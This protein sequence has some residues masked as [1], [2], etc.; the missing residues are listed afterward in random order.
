MVQNPEGDPLFR[1]HESL[2]LA[3]QASISGRIAFGPNAGKLVT[4]IGSGFGYMEEIP[5]AK[6][7]R[8]YSV[9]GFSIHANTSVNALRR[10]KLRKL[11]EYIAR[12]PLSNQRLEI[13]DNKKVKLRL[14]T[15]YSDGT[16]HL[17][18]TFSEFLE[19]LVSIIPLP[20]S[21]LVRWGGVLAPNSPLCKKITLKPEKK[22]GFQFRD[23]GEEPTLKNSSWSKMLAK[24][25]K[26]DVTTCECCGGKMQKI[27]AVLDGEGIR[28]YLRHLNIDP[29]PPQRAPA[30]VQAME[31][32]FD[33]SNEVQEYLPVIQQD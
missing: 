14:K 33:Q 7:K 24:V 23:A 20:K 10:D 29:D 21:H 8:C 13:T 32:D 27:C 11:I 5:L 4:R 25:F 22:K 31:F 26:I 19:R 6:G 12:G 15:P 2:S 28:R 1:D 16:T 18:F 17:V 3:A 30:R 9:N